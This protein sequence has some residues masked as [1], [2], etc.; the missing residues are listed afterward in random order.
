MRLALLV[1]IPL[2]AAGPAADIAGHWQ[3]GLRAHQHSY[4]AAIYAMVGLQGLY[5][6]A[7]VV[8]GLWGSPISSPAWRSRPVS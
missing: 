8:M 1:A 3:S 2:M 7:V 6:A 5:V 4:G